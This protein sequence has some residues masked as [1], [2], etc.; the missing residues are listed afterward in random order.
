MTTL[1]VRKEVAV[2]PAVLDPDTIYFV[3]VGL[4]FD[5]YVT[6][7]TGVIAHKLNGS[8]TTATLKSP[9]FTYVNGV[10]VGIIYADGSFKTF[11]YVSGKISLI[12]LTTNGITTRKKFN[13]TNNVLT[14]IINSTL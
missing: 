13:Y 7:N 10:L 2:L 9:S 12:D 8:Q 1:K 5:L 6:D 14:S 3:R 11:T 4:G